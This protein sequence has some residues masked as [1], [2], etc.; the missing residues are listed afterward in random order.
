MVNSLRALTIGFMMFTLFAFFSLTF[1]D[2]MGELNEMDTDQIL[3]GALDSS[4]FNE[5]LHNATSSAEPVRERFNKAEIV[6]VDAVSGIKD[7]FETIVDF[8]VTPWEL[9][10]QIMTNVL[11]IPPLF[12]HV[13]LSIVLLTFVFLIWR[14]FKQGF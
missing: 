5:S 2:Q 12:T 9:M 11:L 1:I 14:I 6:D 7:I 13:L 3:S 4:I 10:S 8:I